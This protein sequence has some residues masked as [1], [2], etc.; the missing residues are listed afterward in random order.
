MGYVF[1]DMPEPGDTFEMWHEDPDAPLDCGFTMWIV[2][3]S[4]S[5]GSDKHVLMLE[6]IEWSHS[7]ESVEDM[8]RRERGECDPVDLYKVRK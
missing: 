7:T 8:V 2:R 4:T 3:K 1:E 6:R 5:F